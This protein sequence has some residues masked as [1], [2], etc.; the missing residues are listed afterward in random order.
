MA[1]KSRN[2]PLVTAIAATLIAVALAS[3]NAW[4]P[5]LPGVAALEGFTIDARFKLRGPRAP[6]SD[7]V[8]I[9]G[10]DDDLRSTAWDVLQTRR[11]YARF[12]D[13]LTA[14]NPKIIALDF[15]FSVPEVVLPDELASSVK[16]L[17]KQYPET[18]TGD[19]ERET[20][21]V[22]RAVVHELQ[23]DQ[24][25][26][27][28]IAKSGRLFFGAALQ[29]G[30]P[31]PD[32]TEPLVMKKA[33]HGEIVD[34][35]GGGTR[36]PQRAGR[37]DTTMDSMAASAAGAGVVNSF[38]DEDG[39]TRRMPLAMEYLGRHYAPLGLTVAL[40]DLG[41]TGDT[42][43]VVGEPTMD[44]GGRALPVTQSASLMLDMM[45]PKEIPRVSAAKVM[46]GTADRTM[47][48][49]K[50]VFVGF[51]YAAYDKVHTPLDRAAD[52]VEL[53][54]TLAENVLS[55]R[56]LGG[57]GPWAAVAATLLLC[58]IGC[59]AQMRRV[60][61]RPWIPPVLALAAMVGYAVL[62]LIMFGHGTVLAVAAPML[63][64]VMV[65]IAATIGGLAT[66]GRE[67]A[68]LRAVFSQYVAGPVVDRILQ[69]PARARLGGERKELTVLFS[70]IRGF[71]L[72]SEG[73]AP[74]RLA[75][76]LGE[77]LT[78]MTEL[79]LAS[80]GT[81]DKYIGDAVMAIWGAPIDEVD[82]AARACEVALKMQEAL[83]GL[84]KRWSKEGKPAVAIGIGLNTGAMAVG[85][86]GS[87]ARF[88]YTVLGDQVNLGARLEALTKEYG[89]DILCGEATV[90]AAGGAFVFREIDVVRVK[91]RHGAVP[92]FELV[93]RA[94]DKGVSV[95][96]KFGEAL[97]LYRKREFAAAREM[98]A[99]LPDDSVATTM[100]ARC[101]VLV[102]SP[103]DEDWDGVYDQKGK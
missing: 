103:P 81:L 21:R 45:G 43:Y 52:G 58:A 71:S 5:T 3:V 48:E 27:E 20:G 79:V 12:I 17:E 13:A 61:R 10:L 96:M 19:R 8:V 47:L 18:E 25:L 100:A 77:Y 90:K 69:D 75:A 67:K 99:A 31:R 42:R 68:K 49:G 46:D 87:A 37:V 59:A 32:A 62:A 102:A 51:T 15:F 16:A 54:A 41:K 11:G 97:A 44:A 2:V 76:F 65:L 92:V 86:M 26:S 9:V 94:N 22:L 74:E 73:M 36:R 98:F 93:G 24:V 40:A 53:H 72:F 39:V 34:A 82:H 23:G 89:I 101:A 60:R 95:D 33:R 85:N 66:E 83:V 57:A 30:T 63:L 4:G 56:L 14:Y 84:N 6:E 88:D 7:R 91:G 55:G 70:D 1:E 80:G 29:L 78:P 28:S 38:P 64:A 35:G 50:L